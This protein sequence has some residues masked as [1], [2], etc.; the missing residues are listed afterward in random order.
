MKRVVEQQMLDWKESNRRKPLIIRGARQVGKTWLVENFLAREFENLAKI[1]FEERQD[2]HAHFS[3]NLDPKGILQALEITAGKIVPGK[4]LLFLAMC[5]Q[6][7]ASQARTLE[8]RLLCWLANRICL[9]HS[10]GIP[11]SRTRKSGAAPQ[12]M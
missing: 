7:A 11:L 8:S 1:D 2:L 4:T 5:G 10:A 9:C 3:G 6:A 12:W